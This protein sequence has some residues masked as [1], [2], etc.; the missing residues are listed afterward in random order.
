MKT[1]QQ[2]FEEGT[3]LAKYMDQMTKH[4]E[5]SFQIYEQFQVP[6]DDEFIALLKEKQPHIL[7]ITED[8]C[9]D[10]MLNN[11]IL[12]RIAEAASID[13]RTV[14]RDEDPSLIDRHL[15]N[16]GRSI[17][18][19]IVLADDG[20]IIAKW[21]PRAGAIQTYV[22]EKRQ[23][24]PAADAPEFQE[25]QQAFI[26]QLT[27]DYV[28]NQDNWLTVYNDIRHTVLPALQK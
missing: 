23:E 22:L 10:A 15:T 13:V 26:Q 3:P 20:E 18:I 16:G 2:F 11:P 1:E 21:G 8:W 17:P 25:A 24:L 14:L 27:T 12:R 4:K 6:Q 5:S 28:T 7:V 9:G 19:Y